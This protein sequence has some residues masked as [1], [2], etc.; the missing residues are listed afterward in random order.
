MEQ[1]IFN[2]REECLRHIEA[3]KILS[4]INILFLHGEQCEIHAYGNLQEKYSK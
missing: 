4:K 1:N 3:V 2:I